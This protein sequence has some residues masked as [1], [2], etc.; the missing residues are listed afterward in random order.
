LDKL[1]TNLKEHPKYK[2]RITGHTDNFG[3]ETHNLPL[4]IERAK[5]VANYLTGNGIEEERVQYTGVGSTQP[6]AD[7]ET[8]EGRDQNRRVEFILSK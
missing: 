3:S 1:I 5:S 2:V 7:N 4:S 8:K 6:V